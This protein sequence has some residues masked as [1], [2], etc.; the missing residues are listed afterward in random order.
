[1]GIEMVWQDMTTPSL[2][3]T[4]G[5]MKSFPFK[6][7]LTDNFLTKYYGESEENRSSFKDAE[8]PKAPAIKIWNLYSYNL[9][10]ATYHGLNNLGIAG[11]EDKRNFIIGR[12]GFTGMH[13]FAGIWTGDNA[14]DWR[15]LKIN[16]P[17]VLAFGISGQP[18]AG[19]D[20][21]GFEPDREG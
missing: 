7:M 10:K 21:G 9:H 2:R 16:I 15:F 12:G 6:L 14:S 13:R 1:M 3:D 20:I 8:Y 18:V 4:R 5:D 11:R 19:E 17:Q